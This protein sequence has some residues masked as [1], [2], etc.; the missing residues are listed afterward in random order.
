MLKSDSTIKNYLHAFI[1]CLRVYSIKHYD[2]NRLFCHLIRCSLC[3][4]DS[5]RKHYLKQSHRTNGFES[6]H[7]QGQYHQFISIYNKRSFFFFFMALLRVFGICSYG[8]P[9]TGVQ[10]VE[11]ILYALTLFQHKGVDNL[12]NSRLH[13]N[14]IMRRFYDTVFTVVDSTVYKMLSQRPP[15]RCCVR[16]IIM[17]DAKWKISFCL[18]ERF[19]ASISKHVSFMQ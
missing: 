6:T 2:F 13:R 8:I 3:S 10:S 12:G 15:F 17:P 18:E 11:Q 7:T 19:C 4:M 5:K 1:I 9:E 16:L 14:L